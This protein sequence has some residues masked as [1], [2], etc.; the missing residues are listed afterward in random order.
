MYHLETKARVDCSG[1][2]HSIAE[3]SLCISEMPERV[4]EL[5]GI[6]LGVF[7]HFHVNC[8]E[9]VSGESCYQRHASLSANTVV[10]QK[11]VDCAFCGYSL[12]RG[13]EIVV[14]SFFVLDREIEGDDTRK[15]G[16]GI[17]G[18]GTARFDEFVLFG[19]LS[20]SA[21]LKFLRAGL[22]GDRG[23]RSYGEA[24]QLY[25]SSIP[26]Q[27]RNL[28]EGAVLDFLKSKHASHIESVANAPGKARVP[29][30]TLWETAKNN[31]RRGSRDMSRL[32]H[33][34]ANA[35]NGI[36]TAGI[37]GRAV[38]WNATR[39]AAFAALLE[40]P[41]SGT[42]NTIHVVKGKKSRR[43][44]AKDTATDI[45]KAGAAGAVV[46]GGVTVAAALGAGPLIASAAPVA[47][48]LGAG[49][50]AYS[51][52]QRVRRATKD[53]TL[54]AIQLRFHTERT[55][56]ADAQSGGSCYDAFAAAVSGSARP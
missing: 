3:G 10:A 20:F 17:A 26:S 44:A 35:V 25:V 50:F 36:H 13:Q 9:C 21:R 4:H 39:G 34:R 56:C 11:G 47:V 41:V 45:G 31:V 23:F 32:E 37:V 24:E 55:E 22:G 29:G 52:V 27:V 40:A 49:L 28:G 2:G 33:L 48:P 30:N 6:R 7:R 16:Q 14:D 5:R 38:A 19:D 15:T 18:L 53:P 12:T 51:S 1:C 43:G 42:V 54:R 46:A 8:E